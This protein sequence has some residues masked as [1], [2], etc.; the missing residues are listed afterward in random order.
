ME[1]C[2]CYNTKGIY[3]TY[4]N[5]KLCLNCVTKLV[6]LEC[7]YC[8]GKLNLPKD[9]ENIISKNKVSNND[10]NR[11]LNTHLPRNILTILNR[12]KD[13][14]THN[15][16]QIVESINNGHIYDEAYLN[17]YYQDLYREL[18]NIERIQGLY[19]I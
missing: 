18:V 19:W 4:C 5:H 12:I 16:N 2:I 15:Y 10:S 1:C 11:S 8:R 14:S 6:K 3:T 7:P 9:I 17:D 13:I